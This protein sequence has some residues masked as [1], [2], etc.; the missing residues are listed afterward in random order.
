MMCLAKKPI[1]ILAHIPHAAVFE[2]FIPTA[3]DK[4]YPVILLTDRYDITIAS[5][6]EN[7]DAT[8]RL[9]DVF[10]PLAV[11]AWLNERAIAPAAIFSNSDH[12]QTS[13]SLVA[14][15]FELPGKDWRICLSA[16]NKAEM[17][18]RMAALGLPT[19][20]NCRVLCDGPLPANIPFPV[21]AKPSEGVASIDVRRCDD[22]P[23]LKAFIEEMSS[24]GRSEILI[25]RFLEGPL[26]SVETLGDGASLQTIG[27]F[28]VSLSPPPHF[29]ELSARWN[30]PVGRQYREAAVAQIQQFGIGFGACHSEFIATTDGP[31]LVEINY[32]SVGDGDEFL[33]DRLTHGSWFSSILDLHLGRP[34]DEV[35]PRCVISAAAETIYLTADKSGYL[36]DASPSF[37]EE[38]ERTGSVW[39]WYQALRQSGE[40]IEITHS[41]KD[42]VGALHLIAS[43]EPH[44]EYARRDCLGRIH[45]SLSPT[46]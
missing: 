17:R 8:V 14:S 45:F 42:Y 44:L 6:P 22:L 16:K 9:C 21:V 37:T 31:V 5:I 24:K 19:P 4:G 12:L 33:L 18:R 28:D 1:V 2:G 38:K 13:A 26:F 30:G 41:N 34:L 10:N 27:G 25:E 20:W 7:T 15:W 32:R 36:R 3:C 23:S 40:H 39:C 29:V 43:D 11:I 35:I 46:A